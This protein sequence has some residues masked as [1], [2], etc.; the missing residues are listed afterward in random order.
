MTLLPWLR[1][2][3]TQKVWDLDPDRRFRDE[4]N[5]RQEGYVVT[6]HVCSWSEN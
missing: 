5:V 4:L 6:L 3:L 2:G 1:M